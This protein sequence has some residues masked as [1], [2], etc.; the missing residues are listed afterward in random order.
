MSLVEDL[1]HYSSDFIKGEMS[2]AEYD[3]VSASDNR[4]TPGKLHSSQK[5][6]GDCNLAG[7]ESMADSKDTRIL[8]V[9][10]LTSSSAR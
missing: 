1:I 10:A 5:T 4:A 9:I 8:I 6:H 7:S 2:Q 3:S